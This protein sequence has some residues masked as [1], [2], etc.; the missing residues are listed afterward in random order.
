MPTWKTSAPILAFLAIAALF[1]GVSPLIDAIAQDAPE[2][3]KPSGAHETTPLALQC[4]VFP[5]VLEG[6]V[7]IETSD[8]TT[9]IG[10]WIASQDGWVLYSMDFEVGQK[11][12]GFPQGFSQVCL[13][14]AS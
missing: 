8:A 7:T 3:T 2:P 1:Q 9:E 12:T 4:R 5:V 6:D 10:Q 11:S 13:H 14:P